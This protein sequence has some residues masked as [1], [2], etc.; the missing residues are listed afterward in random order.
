[1]KKILLSALLL[2]VTHSFS[3]TYFKFNAPTTLLGIPQVGIE[4]SLA[5]K[6]TY[7]FD[8]LGS[9]W[10]SLNGAP[11]KTIMGISEFRY[12]FNENYKG[13][14]VGGH[15]GASKFELQK[16]NYI[17]SNLYQKGYALF[18]GITIGYQI[19]INDKWMIDMFMG[20]G[21]Q[22]GFYKG[23]YLGTNTRYEHVRNYNKSGEWL[24]YRGGIMFS[25]QL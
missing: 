19:K 7:Q 12:H 23:Y 8:V 17:N 5:K 22:Q 9:H 1:M 14:Y 20:G 6:V 15:I 10:N 21:N 4:T 3:Q 11:F 16:W 25:Y 13:I 18:Y 2:T 24:P